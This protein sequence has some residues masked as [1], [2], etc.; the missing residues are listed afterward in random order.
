MTQSSD[1]NHV[2]DAGTDS[3]ADAISHDV[4]K[5][6]SMMIVVANRLPFI[7]QRDETTG[8]LYRKAR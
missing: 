1:E 8:K 5:Y 2:N 4:V 7:L 3:D 6:S